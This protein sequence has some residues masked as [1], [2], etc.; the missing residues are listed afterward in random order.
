MTRRCC[1]LGRA[2]IKSEAELRKL[3]ADLEALD[4]H[5]T[6]GGGILF[7]QPYPKQ[8]MFL[9][10]GATKRERALFAGNQTG[11]SMTAAFE[12][13]CHLTGWYPKWWAGRRFKRAVRMWACG[14]TSEAVMNVQQSK[15]CGQPGIESSFGTG[16]IPKANL[17]GKSLARGVTNAYDTIQVKHA[18]GGISTLTF[19]SYPE[20]RANFQG[21]SIDAIWLDEEPPDDVYSECLTRTTATNG[22]TY[23]TYTAL[24]GKTLLTDRFLEQ[25]LPTRGVVF[26]DWTEAGHLT[27][28]KRQEMWNS[29]PVHERETRAFGKPMQGEGAIFRT[30]EDRI[31]ED[32]I[33]PAEIPFMW[34]KIWGID[35]GIGHPFGAVLLLYDPDADVVHVHHAIRM[36][37]ALPIMHAAAMKP[38]GADVPVAWPKDAGDRDRGSGEPI[39]KLYKDQGLRVLP[40]HATWPDGSLSTWAGITE[41]DQREQTGRLK[42][43]RHLRDWL[44]ER[45]DYHTKRSKTGAIEIVKVRDDLLSATR[46]G[47]M[48]LR[49]A[50]TVAIGGKRA[51]T[52]SG[53]ASR[54][55][56]GS[57]SHPA[58]HYDLFSV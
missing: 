32:A 55:A 37:D 30:P 5:K 3:L 49:F 7:F 21:E 15:L 48:M 22:M 46:V 56:K 29:W 19:K 45:R 58:G 51:D 50:K 11:K 35:I 23:M 16:M 47:L 43:A 10:M 53:D 9:D 27:A 13:A 52:R 39:I 36:A 2:S 26:L 34:R 40:D 1:G 31:L 41:W 24:K 6:Y 20:G 33:P 4:A 14:E 8:K 54:F 28:E 44:G 12:T 42:V 17:I 18:S 38:I 25:E 57:A